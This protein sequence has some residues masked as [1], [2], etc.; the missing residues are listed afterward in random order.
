MNSALK[1]THTTTRTHT[2]RS[3]KV[4]CRWFLVKL[5]WWNFLFGI[6]TRSGREKSGEV[7]E[8][9]EG[10]LVVDNILVEHFFFICLFSSYICFE[11]WNWW[12]G[13]G[14]WVSCWYFICCKTSGCSDR[15]VRLVKS[16]LQIN[17]TFICV[18]LCFCC[19]CL[20]VCDLFFSNDMYTTLWLHER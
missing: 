9:G 5:C 15:S 4:C 18:C 13:M 2:Q 14:G 17:I 11:L 8:L 10:L 19:A 16:D 20:C 7:W 1:H 12:R 6:H 3:L